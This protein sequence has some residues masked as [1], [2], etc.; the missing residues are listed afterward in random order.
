MLTAQ[1]NVVLHCLHRLVAEKIY[2]NN[3]SLSHGL[4]P[5]FIP[6]LSIYLR[7]IIVYILRERETD[8]QTDRERE[9]E[10]DYFHF[11]SDSCYISDFFW[12]NGTEMRE[13]GRETDRQRKRKSV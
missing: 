4:L 2:E 9:G 12:I 8:R 10:R 5:H 7:C 11:S 6:H 1:S 3:L 13:G